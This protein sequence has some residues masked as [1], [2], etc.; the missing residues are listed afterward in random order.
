MNCEEII[1]KWAGKTARERD[2]WIAEVV[3]GHS[4]GRERRINGEIFVIDANAPH[5]FQR[6]VPHY[7]TDISAAWAVW[8][9]MRENGYEPLINVTSEHSGPVIR[10]VCPIGWHHVNMRKGTV[11][12]HVDRNSAPE[13]IGL[14]AIIAKITEVSADV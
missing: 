6:A 7:T 10:G 9:E 11:N 2:A 14:A 13:A 8:D 12:A 1:A 4:I 3:F 5:G